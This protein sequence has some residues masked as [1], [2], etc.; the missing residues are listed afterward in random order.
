MSYRIAPYLDAAKQLNVKMTVAST[1]EHSLV[2]SI[3][4]G[5]HIDFTEP[6]TA[7]ERIKNFHGTDHIQAVIG[8]DDVSVELASRV[9]D[10]L[11]IAHNPPQSAKCTQRKDLARNIL[12]QANVNVP[13]HHL[14][15]LGKPLPAQLE[16]LNYPCVLKPLAMSMSRGVIRVNNI[17]EAR[18]ACARIQGILKEAVHAEEQQAILVED[19]IDGIEIAYE[20]LLQD[21]ELKTLLL[22]DKPEPLQGPFF[23]ETYYIT[24]SRLAEDIQQRVFETVDAACKA[25]GLVTGPVHAELRIDANNK[26]W[27]IEVA[28]RT[29]GGECARLIEL[30]SGQSLEQLVIANA[31]GKL[32][33]LPEIQGAAGVLM[34]PT[35]E[36][37]VLRRVEGALAVKQIPEV[38]EF[39]LSVREGHRLVPLPEGSSYLGFMYALADTPEQ[40]EQALRK[41][42]DKINVV[43]APLFE[44]ED[45]R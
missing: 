44:I 16:T 25:Y 37:G 42:H 40:V 14:L 11:G 21:G 35:N 23:E 38:K 41:A 1:G 8:A 7:L 5:V 30:A 45:R 9:A 32:K 36:A 18:Q 29:I 10:E 19:Y 34:L 22:F 15:D 3:A 17:E 28:A 26:V 31:L 43:V 4:E 13:A 12:Q 33:T 2:S 39:V 27:V 20:G 24:P 6:E